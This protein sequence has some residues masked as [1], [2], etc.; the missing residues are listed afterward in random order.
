MRGK[1][2]GFSADRDS[3]DEALRV[4]QANGNG[5][6]YRQVETPDE[7]AAQERIVRFVITQ[8]RRGRIG[9]Y[10]PDVDQSDEEAVAEALDMHNLNYGRRLGANAVWIEAKI[11]AFQKAAIV[12]A[13]A[14]S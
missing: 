10:H 9:V 5:A 2:I 13:Q 1:Y 14:K 8:D 7:I 6:V 4:V 11:P 12:K 3:F